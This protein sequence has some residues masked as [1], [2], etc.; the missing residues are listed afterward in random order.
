MNILFW[1]PLFRPDIGGIEIA[2]AEL[3]EGLSAKDCKFIVL[4]SYGRSKE[5]EETFFKKIPVYRFPMIQAFGRR[6]I[7]LL[8]K[9]EDKI[10]AVLKKF[11]PD[12]AHVNFG[13]P[14]PVGYF[15]LKT[16]SI[17]P[18]PTLF[19]LHN[20]V[21]GMNCTQDSVLGRLFRTSDWITA[22]SQA[23]L[24]DARE[25]MPE[26]S[27]K[28][29]PVTYGLKMPEIKPSPLDFTHPYIL[30]LGRLVVEKGFD[31][32]L[33]AL[34]HIKDRFPTV[35]MTIAGNGPALSELKEKARAL[36]LSSRVKF[37]EEIQHEEVAKLINTA[38]LMIVPSR[39]R[40]A[41]GLV[42]LE[43]AQMGR[44]VVASKTGGLEEA[45]VHQK[46]GIL[47]DKNDGE[48][49]AEAVI[50]LLDRPKEAS[51]MGAAARQRART[52][53]SMK[54]YVDRYYHLYRRVRRGH[55]N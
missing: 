12:L 41:F 48:S 8:K 30:C 6:D 52:K 23:M 46:T 39:W 28:S 10:N 24:D 43:A 35:R 51:E 19:T 9:M 20:S 32:A 16:R 18:T 36:G 38:T 49:L 31:L 4:T 2:S 7:R 40:E 22:C 11:K 27:T 47:V 26:I 55:E 17:H 42:A 15:Y 50:Y 34:N 13:G 1:T 44:P 33:E 54:R 21:R 25:M 5:K 53:F 14:A 3:L 45:V 29:S 37:K